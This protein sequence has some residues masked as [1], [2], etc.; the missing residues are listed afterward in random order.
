MFPQLFI[1]H[2]SL[3]LSLA[4]AKSNPT[5]QRGA[6]PHSSLTRRV[7]NTR[8]V[9]EAQS[10]IPRSRVG[11]RIPDAS[12]R[13]RA[14]FLA[15]ASGYEYTRRQRGAEPHSSLTRRVTNT[16]G[17]SEAQSRIPRSRV[18]LRI[19]AASARR[20]A[21]FLAHASGYEYTRPQPCHISLGNRN[22][23]E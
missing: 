23:K 22:N 3:T 15:H 18:G 11:L 21:A 19:H 16:R 2:S 17:L 9:S 4:S 20:R 10:R 14:A 7:T 8:G 1:L 12:A 5:R 13:R 6:E